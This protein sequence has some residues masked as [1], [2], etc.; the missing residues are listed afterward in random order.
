MNTGS[1]KLYRSQ[2]DRMIGGICGGLGAY[3]GID[4]TV[5]RLLFVLI[6]AVSGGAPGV[7][8]YIIMLFIIPEDPLSG[9]T[10]P[11]PVPPA[12]PII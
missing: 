12:D 10:P 3:L 11:P 8:A 9:N 5:V 6:A 4:S 1:K 7:V 2:S